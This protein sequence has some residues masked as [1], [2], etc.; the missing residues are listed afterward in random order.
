[1][2]RASIICM[3]G[4]SLVTAAVACFLAL[5]P[6]LFHGFAPACSDEYA[7]ANET[8]PCSPEWNEATTE[9]VVLGLALLGAVLSAAALIR[10]ARSDE[11]TT[12]LDLATR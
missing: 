7:Q 8:T 3:L 12:S 4:A 1:M 6:L 2:L 11:Q 9:L 10:L 5:D